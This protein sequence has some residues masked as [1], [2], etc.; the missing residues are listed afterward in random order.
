MSYN[1]PYQYQSGQHSHQQPGYEF[2]PYSPT[3]NGGGAYSNN[4]PHSYPQSPPYPGSPPSSS[5]PFPPAAPGAGLGHAPSKSLSGPFAPYTD[6]PNPFGSPQ[7]ARHRRSGSRSQNPN[8]YYAAGDNSFKDIKDY[9][10]HYQGNLWTGG[11]RFGCFGSIVA[12][13]AL[14]LRPPSVL[15]GNPFV[16]STQG[17]AITGQNLVIPLGLNISVDNPTYASVKIQDLT[18]DLTYPITNNPSIGNGTVDN[19]NL[20]SD[21]Q[22]NFTLP[23]DLEASIDSSGLGVIEDIVQKCNLLGG[24][25]S[26]G[27]L[28]V[29]AAIHIKLRA[30]S[31][32]VKFTI[33]R[34][35]DFG[36]PSFPQEVID[37]IQ[38]IIGAVSNLG[39]RTSKR[40]E[41]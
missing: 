25:G 4:Q 24:G 31:V 34:T 23:I 6:D 21:A 22:T 5:S 28:S 19:V 12:G 39:T 29:D 30:L 17:L 2:N 40:E 38:S 3:N 9:R 27:Q 10:A 14:W 33:S 35:L 18:V 20:H 15:I 37:V 26:G 13:L 1:D 11:S 32:P 36:C 8:V 41:F 16:N 7:D